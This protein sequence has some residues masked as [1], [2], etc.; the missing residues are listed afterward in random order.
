[1][2]DEYTPTETDILGAWL[3]AHRE[4]SWGGRCDAEARPKARIAEF[5]RWLQ[6]EREAAERRGAIKAL[7]DAADAIMQ[8]ECLNADPDSWRCHNADAMILSH[9]ANAMEAGR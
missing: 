9:R 3:D 1:M 2:A 8:Q 7:R 5:H 4:P 6:Q